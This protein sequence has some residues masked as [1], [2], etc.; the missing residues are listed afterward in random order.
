MNLKILGTRGEI[1]PS[2]RYHSN[3]SGVLLDN[4]ILLDCGEKK[5]LEHHPDY[6]LIT[7]LHPDH[8]FFVRDPQQRFDIDATIYGPEPFHGNVTVEPLNQ[9]ITLGSYW[10][11]PIPTIH[12]HRVASQ[13]YLIEKNNQKVLYTGDMIWIEKK[14]HPL[15]ENLNLVITEASFIHKGGF[16]KKYPISGKLFGHAGIPNLIHFFQPFTQ[17]LVLVHFG[18]WFY[19]DIKTARQQIKTLAK[20]H[21]IDITV[22]YEGLEISVI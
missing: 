4:C 6:V 14:Y 10:V 16:I 11:T 15:L 3:H 5:F 13:A 21:S 22:G 1:E 9:P 19:R 8:A 7:H 20:Q 12:S 2:A 17:H 18:S